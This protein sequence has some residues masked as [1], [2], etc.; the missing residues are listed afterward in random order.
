MAQ[1]T[2]VATLSYNGN[3]TNS[4]IVTGELQDVLS[5]TKTS[6]MGDYSANDDI[7]YVVS[8]VNSG[9]T[10]FTGLT[11]TDNLGAYEYNSST[12]YP[13]TYV[14]GSIHYYVNGTLQSNPAVSITPELVISG[15]NVPANGN[16]IIVYEVS[17]NNYAP[18]GIEGTITNEAVISGGGLSSPISAEAVIGTKSE[19]QLTISK[20]VC[21]PV[22]SENGQLTY[23][24][25]IQNS[26]NTDAVL[27]DNVVLTDVFD[28]ILDPISV[29]FNGTTW[30]FPA[31]Y[32]YNS[33]TGEFAT[34]AGQ[35]TVPA[36]TY[37]QND[38]GIWVIDPGVA[39]LTV[40]GTV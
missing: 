33:S 34:V 18:L 21:P 22:V 30:T 16:A 8:I 11:V 23:T 20:S 31:N 29:T 24:F 35:I 36:A 38:D 7:T 12:L 2:N 13:L 10:A 25:V 37:T 32:T 4:N 6:I 5:A 40:T 9:S 26:G 28:P 15:I 14:D 19:A 17:A 3:I 1:F 27:A 39:V